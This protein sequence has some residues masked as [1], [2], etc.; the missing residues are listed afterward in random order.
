MK[1]VFAVLALLAISSSAFA[2]GS[3]TIHGWNMASGDLSVGILA[4]VFGTMGNVLHGTS[5]QLLGQ[6]FEIFNKGVLVVAGVWLGYTTITIVLRSAQEGSF[7]GANRNVATILLR[8]ALGIALAIPNPSTGYTILQDLTMKIVVEGVGLA[9]TTWSS[10]LNY[11]KDGGFSYVAPSGVGKYNSTTAV[12]LIKVSSAVFTD[13]VCMLQSRYVSDQNSKLNSSSNNGSAPY[14]NNPNNGSNQQFHVL[15]NSAQNKAIFPGLNKAGQYSS[16]ACGVVSGNSKGGLSDTPEAKQASFLPM[17]QLVVSLLPAAHR[18]QCATSEKGTANCLGFSTSNWE[19]D[20]ASSL[21]SGMY[22][23][24]NLIQ[25]Y[26]RITQNKVNQQAVKFVAN[27]KQLGWMLA[28]RYYWDIAQLDKGASAAT[29]TSDMPTVNTSPAANVAPKVAAQVGNAAKLKYLGANQSQ[30][31]QALANM[32]NESGSNESGVQHQVENSNK[33]SGTNRKGVGFG[34]DG[35]IKHDEN[36]A[37]CAHGLGPLGGFSDS[38]CKSKFGGAHWK[39]LW[40]TYKPGYTMKTNWKVTG[41]DA[42]HHM[43]EAVEDLKNPLKIGGFISNTKDALS[44]MTHP[45]FSDL[46]KDVNQVIDGILGP[47]AQLVEA[48]NQPP[49]NPIQF[50]MHL[51]QL[52]LDVVGEL[53][54][55]GLLALLG[56]AF[57][58]GFCNVATDGGSFSAVMGFIKPLMVGVA[59]LLLVPG[60]ILAYY[61]PLYPFILFTFGAVGWVILVIESIVAA[62]LVAFGLTHPEGHDFLGKAEQ[63]LM[64]ILNVFLRPTLMI[65][66]LIAGM[67]VSFMAF[68]LMIYGFVGVMHDVF[69]SQNGTMQIGSVIINASQVKDVAGTLGGLSRQI[70]NG[71]LVPV[72]MTIFSMIIYTVTKYSFSL[73]HSLPDNIMTWIG[74]MQKSD[75]SAQMVE[76]IQGVASSAARAGGDAV[77]GT[78]EGGVGLADSRMNVARKKAKKGKG[79]GSLDT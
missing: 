11:L 69:G 13:E 48:F 25:P 4:Q 55:G 44:D 19:S 58:M 78:I 6:L 79:S 9:D 37:E 16:S 46:K 10:A 7:M 14:V 30:M 17:R 38:Q 67:L 47:I 32:F 49:I 59:T 29:I 27:A 2:D 70:V 60:V 15:F 77:G 63:S 40:S 23:Y 39:N 43:K 76:Q 42:A 73:V 31:S 74:G 12:K 20:N 56:V 22:A 34:P 68:R 61:L 26:A 51:G 18:Y 1:K 62:P 5:G 3:W 66:G 65:I 24:Y 57:A 21:T 36:V 72:L 50:L 35:I 75:G 54:V 52:S 33:Y 53:W 41:S 8:I 45:S 28:G 71:I 64:L